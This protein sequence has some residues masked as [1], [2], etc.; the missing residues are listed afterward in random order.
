MEYKIRW[1]LQAAAD[2]SVLLVQMSFAPR[3]T[4]FALENK[5]SGLRLTL[6]QRCDQ[7]GVQGTLRGFP[8]FDSSARTVRNPN[9]AFSI[10]SK[11]TCAQSS[12]RASPSRKPV[13][14]NSNATS[15]FHERPRRNCGKSSV[16][17]W[18]CANC[19]TARTMEI[20]RPYQ[21][22][23]LVQAWRELYR[24]TPKGRD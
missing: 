6:L 5:P 3:A 4:I 17:R 22:R 13:S 15:R 18:S 12:E 14:T 1:E 21:I 23:E 19:L 20:P 16:R 2:P 24:R 11:R 9:R 7:A 8:L 10:A